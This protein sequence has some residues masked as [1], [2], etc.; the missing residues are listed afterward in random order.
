MDNFLVRYF[1]RENASAKPATVGETA[2]QSKGGSYANN[3]KTVNSATG[4]LSV[5]A[6]YRG[7]ELRANTMSQLVV[8][9]Q[10]KNNVAHGGNYEKYGGTVMNGSL[11]NYLLQVQ[12]NP[13]MTWSQMMKQAEM[14]RVHQGN[15]VIYIERDMQGEILHFWLC[16]F[17]SYNIVS[18]TYRIQYQRPGG[19]IVFDDVLPTDV[20]HIKNSF[21]NDFGL[22]GIS[23]LRYASKALTLAATNDQL[24]TDTAAKGM[25]QKLIVQE[26]RQGNYGT[27]V[28]ANKKELEKIT[29]KLDRD[30]ADKDVI[31][32]TNI[33][34]VTPIST[35]L[36]QQEINQ[37]RQ[38]SVA[39]IARYLGTPKIM[40]MSSE[41]E[42]YKTPEA[43][44]QEYL[45]RTIAPLAHDWEQELNA[46][47]L[48]PQLYGQFRFKFCD[49]AL[50]RLD[51]VGRANIGKTLIETG[52]KCVNELRADYDLPAVEGGGRHFISTNLQPVD[53]PVVAQQNTKGG[54]A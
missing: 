35:N 32:L 6:W 10:K 44:T 43:A 1:Q 22:T 30:I 11:L 8:E 39:E 23:T 53:A 25:R 50:M 7:V 24:V 54:D 16:S 45:L 17:A 5:A 14:L 51:P 46:K 36:Q 41:N 31:L 29:D 15:A 18:N 2:S 26:E 28:R 12:P 47:L 34:S 33:A 38:F 48:G 37:I 52:V 40:L 13:T 19:N 42:S 4:A 21:S 3:V 27:V 49:D 20:L 9:F